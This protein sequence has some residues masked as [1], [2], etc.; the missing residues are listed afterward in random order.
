MKPKS[1]LARASERSEMAEAQEPAGRLSAREPGRERR[2][3]ERRE[4]ARSWGSGVWAFGCCVARASG[5]R[6]FLPSPV[7]W[8]ALLLERLACHLHVQ[9]MRNVA[10]RQRLQGPTHHC[11]QTDASNASS[12]LA[13][14]VCRFR[15][16]SPSALPFAVSDSSDLSISSLGSSSSAKICLL[17][18]M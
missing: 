3:C 10:C 18:L 16:P 7:Q 12:S 5:S 17:E 14:S 9:L 13:V 1:Q 6:V 15:L 11:A 8:L 4:L 2:K